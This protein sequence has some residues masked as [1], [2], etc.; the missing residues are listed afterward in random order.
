MPVS[1]AV[2]G[3]GVGRPDMAEGGGTNVDALAGAL[4]T[5]YTSIAASLGRLSTTR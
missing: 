5:A 1:Q 2:G 3:K 4:Y